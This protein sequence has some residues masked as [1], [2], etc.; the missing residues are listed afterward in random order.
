[1]H[2]G[3]A[4]RAKVYVT[5]RSQDK[6]GWA[7]E[8][9]AIAGLDSE[10]EFGA[11]MAA[12]GGADVVIDNVGA[13]TMRQSMRAAKKGGRIAICGSTAGPKM[14]LTLPTL[15]FRQL[16]LIGSSMA[17]HAQFARAAT[18]VTTAGAKAPVSK[19]FDFADLPAALEYLDGGEQVGKVVI[20]HPE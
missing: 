7:I 15:F 2:L 3:I 16:E 13:A 10:G 4:M 6:I 12:V 17:N 5:S 11:E 8:Q 9:G 1:M 14:E 18:W 20:R 19:V